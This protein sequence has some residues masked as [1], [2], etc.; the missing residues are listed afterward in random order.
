MESADKGVST[1]LNS[2]AFNGH[3]EVIRELLKHGGK[4]DRAKSN[5]W[6]PLKLA[7]TV[8]HMD[9]VRELQK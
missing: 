6:T 4:V 9:V 8:G 3:V 5:G 2:A 7:A 1:P